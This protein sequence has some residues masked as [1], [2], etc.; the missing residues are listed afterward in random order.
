M[1]QPIITTNKLSVETNGFTRLRATTL[2]IPAGLTCITG[3]SGSGKSTLLKALVGITTPSQ[4]EVHH[5]NL[6]GEAVYTN[7]PASGRQLKQR[8]VGWLLLDNSRQRTDAGYRS[9]YLGYIPQKPHIPNGLTAEEYLVKPHLARGN[10][11]DLELKNRITD[12]LGITELLGKQAVALSG[13]E[14]Q[15]VTTA[16]ALIH[17]PRI[18]FADEPTAA[19]D[20]FNSKTTMTLLKELSETAGMSVVCVTHSTEALK[21]ADTQIHLADNRVSEIRSL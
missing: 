12:T 20:S 5:R 14:Q 1:A 21:F 18:V 3:V 6:A 15:R 9:R 11:V 17:E 8:T 13:G 4:G 10:I 16:F 7:S 2:E 19:L